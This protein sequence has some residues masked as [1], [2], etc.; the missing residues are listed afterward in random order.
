MKYHN[1]PD[2]Q[3]FTPTLGKLNLPLQGQE[4]DVLKENSITSEDK[5]IRHL[6]NH[7]CTHDTPFSSQ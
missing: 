6:Q 4:A 1:H 5:L 3:A 7:H 2:N